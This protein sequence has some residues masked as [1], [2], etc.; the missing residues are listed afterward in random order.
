MSF[1]ISDY[2]HDNL[3]VVR[4]AEST[5]SGGEIVCNCLFC[6]GN[7]KLWVNESKGR[8]ICYKCGEKGSIEGLVARVEGVSLSEA[9]RVVASA[10]SEPLP[11]PRLSIV[12]PTPA[13]Y[14]AADFSLPPE[15]VP[16][17]NRITRT[18]RI[19]EFLRKRGISPRIAMA[20]GLGFCGSG[21]AAGR[22]ICPVTTYGKLVFYT[23][24]LMFP[25]TPKWW[26]PPNAKKSEA[27]YGL[28]AILGQSE[29]ILVEGPFDVLALHQ[30]GLP[31]ICCFGTVMSASQ[32]ALICR[33]G[34]K[35]L[36]LMLDADPA[37]RKALLPMV[38]GALRGKFDLRLVILPD[39]KDPD[40]LSTSALTDALAGQVEA[41]LG[42]VDRLLT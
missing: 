6:S 1:N 8:W 36:I 16:V 27:V 18:W 23:G 17:Y 40:D 33:A 39:G 34:V 30:R 22:L 25:G 15:F 35:K 11:D 2:V 5:G 24:R 28:D 41:T 7:Q 13:T 9:R 14:L 26:H 31:G 4:V 29:A 10:D 19:P 37:G 20:W 12:R 32:E 38:V 21:E 3:D 42:V